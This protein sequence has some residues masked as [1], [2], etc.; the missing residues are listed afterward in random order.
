M[1]FPLDNVTN[2]TVSGSPN[3]DF[4]RV[5]G[6]SFLL[7][8]FCVVGSVALG[9]LI[10]LI[11][12]NQDVVGYAMGVLFA[13]GAGA[14]IGLFILGLMHSPGVWSVTLQTPNE[15]KVAYKSEDKSQAES[16][17]ETIR[18]AKSA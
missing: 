5:T 1:V 12:N 2:V 16:I 8:I 15:R 13:V 17:A 14:V 18:R 7:F 9:Y 3:E 4:E 11:L 6:L 10:G